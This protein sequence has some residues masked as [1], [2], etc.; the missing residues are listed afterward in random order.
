MRTDAASR[1]RRTMALAVLAVLSGG[2]PTL[3]A[4]E[5]ERYERHRVPADFM[6]FRGAQ[7]LERDERVEE[8][9][10]DAV[11]E[12]MGLELGDVAADIG[13]GSGYYARRMAGRVGSAGRVYCVDIQPEMLDIMQQLA[14][15]D[16]VTGV[17]PVLSEVDDP[18]LPDAEVDWIILADVYHEMSDYEA[19]L[20]GMRAALA[21]GGRVALL[22]YRVEDGTGDHLKSD[23]AMSVR[24]VLAEWL[25]AGFELV[26][27]L[28]F[29]PG[30]HLFILKVAGDAAVPG[31]PVT[32]IDLVDALDQGVVEAEAFGAGEA[33]VMLRVRNL[34]DN[35]LIVT[36]PAGMSFTSAEGRRDMV[37][38]RDAA[39]RLFDDEWQDWVVRAVG[40][41]QNRRAPGSDDALT[42]ALPSSLPALDRLAH[43][44]QAGTYQVADSPLQYVPRAQGVEQAAVWVAGEDLGYDDIAAAVEDPRLPAQYAVAFALVYCDLAGIDVTNRRV[45]ADRE[46]IFGVLRD[47]G[48]TA[49]YQV[50]TTGR[51]ER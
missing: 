37:S 29:L 46:R 16:G 47:P 31:D 30:Q 23:H 26:D 36:M 45:W 5:P 40:R 3:S 17:V 18:K 33:G 48:L 12:V 11:L 20:A 32:T 8:E 13:C 24:Q 44:M 51:T 6:S 7:W 19:M 42:M 2:G 41:Q 4:Q 1:C 10:P 25:P 14:D 34:G 49:W 15:R 35:R 50:K 28:E 9:Q 21:P 22:E 43:V 27:L 39:I 38:R